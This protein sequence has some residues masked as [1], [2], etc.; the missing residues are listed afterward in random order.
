MMETEKDRGM[1]ARYDFTGDERPHPLTV[2]FGFLLLVAVLPLVVKSPYWLGVVIVAMY[3]A[4]QAAAW[5]LLSGYV[6]QISLAPATFAMLGG[7]TSGLLWHHLGIPPLMGI[8]SAIVVTALLGLFLGRITFKLSG[9]YFTLTTLGF[10]EISRLVMANSLKWTRGDLGLHLPALLPNRVH[11]Y[12]VFLVILAL[13]Q[14]GLYGLLRSRVGLF[15]QAIRDD[16]IAAAGRGVDVVRWKT[17]AFALSSAICGLGGALYVH[18]S[19]LAS[20]EMGLIL[21]SGLVLSMVVVGGLGTLVGPLIGAFIVQVSSE[22]LRMV[23]VRHMLVFAL[24]VIVVGRF[25]RQGLWGVTEQ[26]IVA[27]RR[28][29]RIAAEGVAPKGKAGAGGLAQ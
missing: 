8:G 3:F 16:E 22:V 9:P 6:G 12:Y 10:A 14:L 5:N 23:G 26:W 17:V 4:M 24:L 27:R 18:F 25:L 15:L 7:Y 19:Q 20:P 29:R 11:T 2:S 13:V 21:Q 1:D 28:R